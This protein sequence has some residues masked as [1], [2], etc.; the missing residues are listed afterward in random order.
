MDNILINAK[1]DIIKDI[2]VSWAIQ[3]N[4]YW[5]KCGGQSYTERS[6]IQKSLKIVYYLIQRGVYEREFDIKYCKEYEMDSPSKDL[7]Q[8]LRYIME[9]NEFFKIS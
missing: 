8:E 4:I 7:Y 6:V 3:S 2:M 1:P 5:N 9:F